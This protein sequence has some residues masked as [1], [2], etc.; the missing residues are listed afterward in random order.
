MRF[1]QGPQESRPVAFSVVSWRVC[2][3]V[4]FLEEY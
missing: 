1:K 2:A 3:V 4:S